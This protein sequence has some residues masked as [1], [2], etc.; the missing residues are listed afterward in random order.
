M[1]FFWLE[2]QEFV[3]VKHEPILFVGGHHESFLPNLRT[4]W[5]VNP[6]RVCV[7]LQ[8]PPPP[9][10]PVELTTKEVEVENKSAEDL[11][12][13]EFEATAAST[14]SSDVV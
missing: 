12:W 6:S 10:A 9:E 13:D 11:E 5:A 7:C 2:Q 3:L 8:I 4:V 1:F 14:F